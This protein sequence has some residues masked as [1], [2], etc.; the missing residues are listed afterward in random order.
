MRDMKEQDCAE[1]SRVVCASFRQAVEREDGS[2]DAIRRYIA[3]RGCEDAIR[4]QFR[5][6][7][8]LVACS[9]QTI[10]GMIGVL[11]NKITKLYV[12]PPFQHQGIG[13]MLFEAAQQVVAAAGY[14]EMVAWV[15]FDAAIPFYEAMGMCAVGR[16]F[17]LLGPVGGGN[18]LLTKKRLV[19]D[20][21]AEPG[22]R[23]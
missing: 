15:A 10:V 21:E 8:C 20:E 6:Y 17:D 16:K 9:R 13:A 4:Q 11:G 7:R 22:D 19:V 18:A 1:V 23:L 5:E 2:E 3:S 12:D 14:E